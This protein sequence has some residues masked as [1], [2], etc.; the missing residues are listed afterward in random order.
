MRIV[1]EGGRF[2]LP[3]AIASFFLACLGWW[4]PAG[5]LFLSAGTFAFFFRDPRRRIAGDDKDILSPA[6]GRV[7]SI[8]RLDSHPWLAPPVTR[9]AIFL[10]LLDVHLTRSPVSGIVDKVEYR[11]GQF[12]RAY[13]DEAGQMNESYSLSIRGDEVDVH[14]KQIV[15]V[16]ARRIRSYIKPGERVERGQK[17]GLMYFGSRVEIFLPRT[18][19]PN[20]AVRQKVR[21]GETII[22]EV[23]E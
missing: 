22:A 21:S 14:L 1:K 3:C 17:I 10:S 5:V 11:P 2:I 13:S 20:V 15:G 19:I 4:V 7:L 23:K 8:E 12:F 18:A 9:I 16:A 6:D